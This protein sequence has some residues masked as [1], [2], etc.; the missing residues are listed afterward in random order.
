V[1]DETIL[2]CLNTPSDNIFNTVKI[3]ARSWMEPKLSK[4]LLLLN[5]S[6]FSGKVSGFATHPDSSHIFDSISLKLNVERTPQVLSLACY[7]SSIDIFLAYTEYIC[8][9]QILRWN[10]LRKINKKRWDNLEVAWEKELNAVE[11]LG[12]N[13]SYSKG[14]VYSENARHIRF[15]QERQKDPLPAQKVKFGVSLDSMSITLRRDDHCDGS[16]VSYAYNLSCARSRRFELTFN[17]DEKCDHLSLSVKNLDLK[18]LGEKGR[19]AYGHFPVTKSEHDLSVF[20][21]ILDCYSPSEK[22]MEAAGTST[23]NDSQLIATLYIHSSPSIEKRLTVVV[24]GLNLVVLP[25]PIDDIIQFC[26]C[27]WP[28]HMANRFESSHTLSIKGTHL[29]DE[30]KIEPIIAATQSILQV[31]FVL[32]YPRLTLIADESDAHSRALVFRG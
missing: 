25:R 30:D 32:H 14:V 2:F 4:R 11:H 1:S 15:G 31:K 26:C 12:E 21:T 24:N 29:T 10:M 18:D 20:S 13:G 6:N 7:V 17:R 23:N 28:S 16:S 3:S 27:S 5:M 8:L 9:R 19:Y 22:L